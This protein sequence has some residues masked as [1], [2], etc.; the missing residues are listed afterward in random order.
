[1]IGPWVPMTDEEGETVAK[2]G[3]LGTSL[4]TSLGEN[5]NRKND[6]RSVLG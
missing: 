3:D 1:M 2:G 6:A 4:F 5:L